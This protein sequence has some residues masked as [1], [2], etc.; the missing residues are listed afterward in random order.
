MTVPYIG[1]EG[2]Q[3]SG[4][5]KH[6]SSALQHPNVIDESLKKE[7]EAGHVLGPF[8]DPP[9]PNL[10]CSGLGAVPKH[11]GGWQ[12]IYHLSVLPGLS[13]NDFINPDN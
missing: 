11:D 13:I 3:F 6:L 12:I 5:A 4:N 10:W 2:P 9:L 1:Y 8:N 7:A